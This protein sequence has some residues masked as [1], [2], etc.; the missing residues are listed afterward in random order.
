M[1]TEPIRKGRLIENPDDTDTIFTKLQVGDW[2]FVDHDR[3]IF[4]RLPVP[5]GH[6]SDGIHFL[7]IARDSR[8]CP[9]N[10]THWTWDGNREAPTLSPS[11]LAGDTGWHGYMRAGQL[12]SV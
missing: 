7:A 6:Y 5:E 8:F 9:A 11:I 3:A 12:E 4:V 1:S 10:G 2:A